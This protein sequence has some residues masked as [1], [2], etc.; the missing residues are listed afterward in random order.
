MFLRSYRREVIPA[1]DRYLAP[2]FALGTFTISAIAVVCALIAYVVS[3]G[4]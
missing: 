3:G 1:R 2:V 4:A